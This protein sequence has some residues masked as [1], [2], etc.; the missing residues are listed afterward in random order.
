MESDFSLVDSIFITGI[1]AEL[2]DFVLEN[3]KPPSGVN[4]DI[5]CIYIGTLYYLPVSTKIEL[6]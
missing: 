2:A 3:L 4:T 6:K 1:E 5:Q